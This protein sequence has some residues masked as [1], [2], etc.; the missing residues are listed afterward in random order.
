[1]RGIHALID[2][3]RAEFLANADSRAAIKVEIVKVICAHTG[4]SI[5]AANRVV[6]ASL[7]E[8]GIALLLKK[9]KAGV[10]LKQKAAHG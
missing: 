5:L 8:N 4:A 3:T 9:K 10:L 1:L 6:E 7:I 2:D